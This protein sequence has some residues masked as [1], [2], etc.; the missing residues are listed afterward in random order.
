LLATLLATSPTITIG[1]HQIKKITT[2]P[3]GQRHAF[4]LLGAPI[5][6]TLE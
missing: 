3:P 6:I 4:E 1:G 2:P 5:G